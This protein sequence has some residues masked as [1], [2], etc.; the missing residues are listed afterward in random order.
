MD[1]ERAA[2]FDTYMHNYLDVL[3][4]TFQHDRVPNH[5]LSLHLKECLELFG[6]VHAWWAFPFERFNGM[7]Q[8]LNTN[9]KT[10]MFLA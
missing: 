1:M 5:H 8:N 2:K 6:P 9:S 10:S 7:I 4:T 3:T